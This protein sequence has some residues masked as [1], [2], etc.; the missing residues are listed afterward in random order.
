[1][2]NEGGKNIRLRDQVGPIGPVVF[3]GKIFVCLLVFGS[4]WDS[5]GQQKIVIFDFLSSDTRH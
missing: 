2:W 3:K 1:M 4:S 5:I